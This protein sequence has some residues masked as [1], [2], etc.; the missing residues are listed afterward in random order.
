MKTKKKRRMKKSIKIILSLLLVITVG[1]ISITILKHFD[2]QEMLIPLPVQPN[3]KEEKDSITKELE[4]LSYNDNE[5]TLIQEYVTEE[6]I[7]YLI[8]NKINHEI[9]YN[10]VNE[11]YYIDDYL[12]DYL[13][14]YNEHKDKTIK[15]IVTIINTHINNDFYTNTMKTDTSLG[16]YVI[17]NKYYYA[18]DTYPSENLIKV[19]GKYH[20][21]GTSF[22]LNDE[23]YEAFLKMYNDAYNAG[24][25]FKM[26]SAYRS[27]DTQVTT[28]NYWVS[29]ENGDKT[30]ADIYSARAGFSEHQTGYAFDIRDYNWEYEDYGK[31]ESFKWVSEN[32]HKYGFI[33]RFPKG[34]EHITGYQYESWHYR[35]C[36][37]ECATYIYEN[38]ITFEEYYEYFIKYNNPKNLS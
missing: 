31:S 37:I 5:I 28:Y 29:T 35:Y 3:K 8:N 15:E 22:Y 38:D 17:L 32:T 23:C 13:S 14:Y 21:N 10:F 26:K 9:A 36:G 27:Y 6:N 34:K 30:K 20:V 12:I 24:Y 25:G 7:N 2:N 1:Y 16:K 11:T 4:K 18:D 33:I 19:D